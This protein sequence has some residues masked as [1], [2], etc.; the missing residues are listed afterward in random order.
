MTHRS[1]YTTALALALGL[2]ASALLAG[3]GGDESEQKRAEPKP[4]VVKEQTSSVSQGTGGYVVTWAGVLVNPNRWLFGENVAATVV[5]RDASGKEV[6]RMEQPLD[7]VPP[8]GALKFTGQATASA[9]PVD[10]RLTYRP[11]VWRKASRI[12]SAYVP[13]PISSA[14]TEKLGNGSYLVT[15]AVANPFQR[16]ATSLVVTALLRDKAGKLIGG[17]STYVDDVHAG[18]PRR[19]VLTVDGLSGAGPVARTDITARTW[20]SSGRPYE[21]LAMSGALPASTAKPRTPPFA[22]D[23]GYQAMPLD[24]RP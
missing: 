1:R 11:A 18:A 8:S 24:R 9:R 5:G 3:C 2:A 6:V 12:P 4:L 20:G 21:E 14:G 15:G 10:V 13:F 7:A 16:A 17:A 22:R 19:F 23:R